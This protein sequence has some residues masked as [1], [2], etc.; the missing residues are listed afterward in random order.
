VIGSAVPDAVD[1]GQAVARAE[2]LVPLL[3]NQAAVLDA[4]G[5]F[6]DEGL[7]ALRTSGL[8]GLLVPAPDGGLGGG[9]SDLAAVAQ[10]LAGGCLS[11]AM[12]WA[13]H[14]QQVDAVVRYGGDRLRSSLLP[15]IA[16]GEVY[17]A[18]ITTEPG[19][20]G[21]L[22]SASS[23]VHRDGAQLTIEREAPVVT[24]G[25]Q[26]DGFLVTMRSAAGSPENSVSLIYLDRAQ[27][28]I[29]A[30]GTGWTAMG[31]RGTR[32]G[33][34]TLS[35]SVPSD[36]T[37][38]LPGRFRA[39]AVESMIP[40]GHVAWAACWLGA[41]RSAMADLVALIRS[42][43]RPRGLDPRSDLVHERLARIRIDLELVGAY[44]HRTVDEISETRAAGRSLDTAPAQIHLNVLKVAAAEL[45]FRAV[46]RLVQLAG[47]AVG[48]LR[49]SPVPLERHFRDL[50]SASLNNSDDRLLTATGALTLL[51]RAV[52]TA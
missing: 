27:A 18:S 28:K 48:Y 32:S 11:T 3:R 26:A 29:E 51:D 1:R 31:M 46:D 40:I 36:Q 41:A 6:P 37:I 43:S 9:P 30:V 2:K 20:G 13:M 5:V 50:R 49:E 47:L 38:G 45:T 12:I 39:V 14:C 21:H 35:G 16:R 8:L 17:L 23:P 24:G 33:G 15:R 22:L 42:P 19:K 34:L 44:L 10:T 25:E 4:T 7:R 52:V